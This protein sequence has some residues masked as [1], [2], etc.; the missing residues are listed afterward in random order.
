LCSFN[1]TLSTPINI[2][3]RFKYSSLNIKGTELIIILIVKVAALCG[4]VVYINKFQLS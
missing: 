3:N 2:D 1:Q 4:G